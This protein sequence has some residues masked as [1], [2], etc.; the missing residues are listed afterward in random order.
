M[1]DIDIA[2]DL[3]IKESYSLV[4][5][6]DG[7]IITTSNERGLK[8]LME[9]LKE[10]KEEL[11]GAV[12]ADKIIGKAG[13]LL[14]IYGGVKEIYAHTLSDCAKDILTKNEMKFESNRVV[15]YIINRDG[16]DKCPM[17][18]LVENIESPED[19]YK[20]ILDFILKQIRK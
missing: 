2:K 17:E 15:P 6:K 20:S 12:L 11:E 18:K 8:P 13:A 4:I 9:A 3:L 16:S 5:Y 19:A 14:A 10:Y 1:T 7:K